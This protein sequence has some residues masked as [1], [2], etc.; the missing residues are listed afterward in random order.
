[1]KKTVLIILATMAMGAC[2]LRPVNREILPTASLTPATL[3]NGPLW[4]EVPAMQE[5]TIK[6][7]YK[8]NAKDPSLYYVSHSFTMA[9][10]E[11]R[12]YT[13]CFSATHHAPLWVAAP[14]HRVYTRAGTRRSNVFGPDPLLPRDI[15]YRSNRAGSECNRGHLLTSAD[16]LCISDANVQVFYYSNIAPQIMDGFNDGENAGWNILEDFIDRQQC[17]DTLYEVIGAYYEEFTDAYGHTVKPYT[18]PSFGGR[19]DVDRPTMFY[20]AVLR[21]KSGRSGKALKDCNASELK[22]AAF[23]RANTG[24]LEYQEVTRKEM[25]SISDLEKLTGL[26][27]FVNVPQ[28]PE[29]ICNPSDWGL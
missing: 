27:F 2:N 17:A 4:Y 28:A 19:S 6:G 9:G 1:M 20:Y 23:A 25:M 13:A 5:R 22:C 15:Q 24:K 12:N 26:D 11:Y 21:T 7:G 10:R 18:L 3:H 8:V 16:R 29:G 14:R